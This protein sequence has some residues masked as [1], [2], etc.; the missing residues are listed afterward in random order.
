MKLLRTFFS[1]SLAIVVF[2]SCSKDDSTP[3]EADNTPKPGTSRMITNE[4]EY[5]SGLIEGTTSWAT[6]PI[7]KFPVDPYAVSYSVK[8]V[9]TGATYT[10][11]ADG[12][13]GGFDLIFPNTNSIVDG[14]YYISL[15]RT[16]CA[17]CTEVDP[18]WMANYMNFFGTNNN[19]EITFFY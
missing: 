3:E 18:S 2:A 10:W 12:V 6:W 1:L 19:V 15:D 16:W 9:I 8:L 7:A 13:T 11:E 14:N 5:H 4:V 17:G